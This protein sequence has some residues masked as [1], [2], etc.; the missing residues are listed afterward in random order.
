MGAPSFVTLEV[1]LKAMNKEHTKKIDELILL[2]LDKPDLKGI[3]RNPKTLSAMIRG[4]RRY[5]ATSYGKP[6]PNA[7]VAID[8]AEKALSDARTKIDAYFSEEWP[9]YQKEV[10]ALTFDL[11]DLE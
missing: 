3:Q 4:A 10:E 6:T 11:F 1:D 5:L 7:Q 9:A 8:K 2:Y